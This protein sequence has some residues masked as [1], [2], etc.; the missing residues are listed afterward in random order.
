PHANTVQREHPSLRS[1][2]SIPRN[3]IADDAN[4]AAPFAP[5]KGLP[6]GIG[7]K[8]G[9]TVTNR[10]RSDSLAH[11]VGRRLRGMRSR[12]MM[13][14]KLLLKREPRPSPNW[15]LVCPPMCA[16]LAFSHRHPAQSVCGQ[17]GADTAFI[18][19]G[20]LH[21]AIGPRGPR[22]A[23]PARAESSIPAAPGPCRAVEDEP[24]HAS[25][26]C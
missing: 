5:D 9:A 18:S 8:V 16:I 14:R 22:R 24:A 20:F 23:T 1:K 11:E 4:S 3:A 21:S 7:D 12:A 6:F 19:F 26:R 15:S 17:G 25:R 13:R 10:A 2:K